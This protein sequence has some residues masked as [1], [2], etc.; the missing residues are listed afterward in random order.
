MSYNL[1]LGVL[2]PKSEGNLIN[3]VTKCCLYN[4][5]FYYVIILKLNVLE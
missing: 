1:L 4:D 2:F 5:K 3:D